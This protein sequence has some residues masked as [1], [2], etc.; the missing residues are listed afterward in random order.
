MLQI[1]QHALTFVLLCAG[2]GNSRFFVQTIKRAYL[3]GCPRS[4]T[5]LA[6]SMIAAHPDVLTF[7]EVAF[8]AYMVRLE[9]LRLDSHKLS[10]RTPAFNIA[11]RLSLAIGITD[12]R[13]ARRKFEKLLKVLDRTDLEGLKPDNFY[14]IQGNVQAYLRVLETVAEQQ[15]KKLWLDK[16]PEY[17][18]CIPAIEKL[19]SGAKFVHIVRNGPDTIASLYDAAKKYSQKKFGFYKYLDLDLC[20][21]RWNDSVAVSHK[22]VDRPNHKIIRYESLVASPEVLLEELCQF[23]EIEFAP[24]ILDKRAAVAGEMVHRHTLNNWHGRVTQPISK[25]EQ[26]FDHIFDEK[27]QQYIRARLIRPDWS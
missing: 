10:L 3:L 5:T 19:I 14:G 13:P 21:K 15:Q 18:F 22:Y 2:L 23:L 12:P 17:V 11:R 16:S 26:K 9:P 20:I 7:A 25:P 4:G 24:E 1:L 6:Q 8:L 27:Q